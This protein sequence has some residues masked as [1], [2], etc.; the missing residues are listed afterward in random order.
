MGLD[1]ALLGLD[2]SLLQALGTVLALG[3]CVVL[4]VVASRSSG[5][6]RSLL[7]A[8][9]I[10]ALT[11][12]PGPDTG[13][14]TLALGAASLVLVLATPTFERVGRM[15]ALRALRVHA[16]R[17]PK[18]RFHVL[19][20]VVV[21][22]IALSLSF[23]LFDGVP[24]IQ[25]SQA[26]LFHARILAS[27]H[28][29]LPTPPCADHLLA[30]HVIVRP[31]LY[32]QYPPGHVVALTLGV[33]AHAPFLVCPILGGL[34][35]LTIGALARA[36]HGERTAR[37]AMT[38]GLVSPFVLLM[39]SE[40]MSHATGLLLFAAALLAVV[41]F[42]RSGSRMS[43]LAI[44]VLFGALLL[45][46]PITAIALGLPVG[47]LLLRDAA[48]ERRLRAGVPIA[49]LAAVA[50]SAL[51]LAW[52]QATNGAPFLMGYV[53]RWGPLHTFGFHATPWGEPHTPLLGLSHT[54]SNGVAW[55]AYLLGG[56]IPA[57][58]LV[59][60]GVARDRRAPMTWALAMA[61]VA[62]L[63]VHAF[64]FFQDLIFGP[65]YLY[66]A[67]AAALVLAA[68]GLG[69]LPSVIRPRVVQGA[70][71]VALA[72]AAATFWPYAIWGY[73]H[74]YCPRGGLVDRTERALADAGVTAPAIVFVDEP[75]ERAFFSVHPRLDESRVLFVRD[76]GDA[77]D[78]AC[79][80]ELPDRDPW[81]VRGGTL[82]RWG[83]DEAAA[84]P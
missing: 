76:L 56:P 9:S 66:E 12:V 7:G 47:V 41:R 24:M 84:R 79:M 77:R 5:A 68:R 13:L 14:L 45:T 55:N 6:P 46:R 80:E 43:A 70:A 52:N 73:H 67:S 30:D 29:V 21:V 51:L 53:V 35:V 69:G 38:L 83:A 17:M 49:A 10:A 54:L 15:R 44:G 2:P 58:F 36:L 16:I 34:A 31:A 60:L 18:A 64:Y 3:A 1:G 75:Y 20:L 62:I 19:V 40:A 71:W 65:R 57:M 74:G 61:P 32:S 26:Q 25:D 4:A 82:Q 78:A 37:R 23:G 50:V 81:I 72:I 27:G 22:S 48:R 11:C 63:V 8:A 59:V 42:R 28:V 39:S 33:L